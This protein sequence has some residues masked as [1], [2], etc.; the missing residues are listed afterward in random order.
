MKVS[1]AFAVLGV[2]STADLKEIKAAYR[3]RVIETHPDKGGNS[4]DFIKVRAAYEILCSF[5]QSPDIDDDVPIPDDLRSII[6]E[7]VREFR[8]QFQK[9]EAMCSSAFSEFNNKMRDTIASGGRYDLQKF[10]EAFR[11]EWNK[12][13]LDLFQHFN[14]NCRAT[15]HKYEGWFHK[16]MEP[17]FEEIYKRQLRS[18][19][20]SPAFYVYGVILLG[21]GSL[22]AGWIYHSE[23]SE[24]IPSVI[25]IGTTPLALLPVVYWLD[26]CRS[27]KTPADVHETLSVELFKIDPGAEFQGS[28]ILK[29]SSAYTAA[30]GWGGFAIGDF[31]AGGHPIL[32]AIVGLVVGEVVGRIKNPTEKMRKMISDQFDQF[33]S[34]AQRDV[35]KYVTDSHKKLMEDIQNQVRANYQQGVKQTVLLI[36][37]DRAPASPFGQSHQKASPSLSKQLVEACSAGNVNEVSQLLEKGGDPNLREGRWGYTLLQRAVYRGNSDMVRL[38]LEKGARVDKEAVKL[39]K[40][41]GYKELSRFLQDQLHV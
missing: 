17:T 37:S 38:L 32:G 1:E 22:L 7:I 5:L 13:V 35:T 4:T 15:I 6:D 26:C 23:L 25:L 16:T 21:L 34:I 2:S 24:S 27:R 10:G 9:S 33:V 12:L 28:A 18:F 14:N 36:A 29:Q 39:A 8:S 11:T 31:I 20:S 40:N 41:S 19:A 3:K 30:A